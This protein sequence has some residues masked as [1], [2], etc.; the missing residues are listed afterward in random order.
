MGS[1]ATSAEVI[2][3]SAPD[4]YRRLYDYWWNIN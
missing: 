3:V 1:A 2:T 4:A